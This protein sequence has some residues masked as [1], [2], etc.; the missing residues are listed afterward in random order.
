MSKLRTLLGFLFAAWI[1]AGVAP[2]WCG[3]AEKGN[4]DTRIT[5]LR[6]SLKGNRTCLIFD[7]EGARPKQ[8]GPASAEGIS[9]FFSQTTTKLPDKVFNESKIAAKEVKFRR[10]S[11]FFEVLFRRNNTTVSSKVQPGK[12]G[13]YTLTLELTPPAKGAETKASAKPA[14]E[15]TEK[16]AEKAPPIEIK[17]VET[18]EL[19]ASK[20][21][22]QV[23][24][25]LANT[26]SGSRGPAGDAKQGA[27]ASASGSKAAA[28]VEPDE[29]ALALYSSANEMFENCSRNLVSCA[30][31]VIEAYDAALKAGPTSSQAPLA[32]YRSALAHSTMGNYEKADKLFRQV[33]S[34]WP[35]H[36]VAIRCWI[37]IG[38]NHNRKQ[39]YLEA[40]EA[41]RW[42]LRGAE[43]SKDKAVAYYK[44]GK[45]YLLLGAPKEALEMLENCT[46]LDPDYYAKEPDVLR[47]SGE[48]QFDL[49]NLEKAKEH[50]LK[51]VNYQQ[52]ARDQ[53]VVFAKIAEIFLVQGDVSSAKKMY[54]FV[55]KYFTESEGDIICKIRK[56]EL[57]EKDDPDRSIKIYDALRGK[58][59]SPSLRRIVLLKLAALTIKKGDLTRSLELMDEAFPVKSDGSSPQGTSAFR[60][61]VLCDL[62]RRAFSD[63][64]FIKVVQLHDKYRRVFDSI[65]SPD[66]L[67]QIAESYAALKF[68]SNSLQIYDTLIA[69]GQKKGD[70]LLLRCAVYALRINDNGRAFQFCK[71]AQS[72]ALDLKKSEILG[73]IFYRDQ[74][75]ADALKYFGKVAPKGKELELEDPNSL[76]VFGYCLYQTKKFDEA[77]PVL[78]KA[79]LKPKPGDAYAR[80]SMLVTLG[81]CFAEQKQF[82]K[83]AETMEMAIAVS[84]E[85]QKNDLFYEISKLYIAAGQA[86]KA[87]QNL[88][89]IKGTGDPFWSAVAQQQ[90][91]TI[92]I[93]QVK[94]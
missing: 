68:Y 19:F 45:V 2:P 15:P 35:D 24:N 67:E 13:K 87:I 26:E 88:N 12:N 81:K 62:V 63:K 58:D 6:F 37:G 61:R 7:A 47:C 83:A 80:R 25:A 29:N 21:S 78:Q 34:R 52:S 65:Q 84:G 48:A 18:S 41:F 9:V 38:D 93:S 57:T 5:N 69:K 76:E 23:K 92:D 71:L 1:I 75:Y 4:Q 39:S 11:G 22:Q 28:F 31:D 56:A 91:N 27:A 89:Q 30:P 51:Y 72:D 90:I 42:A 32:I 53:D 74:K 70:D 33:I 14:P 3:A 86:D 40:V 8:I 94:Q 20:I 73:H 60:E 77:I 50:L 64:D 46:R 66:V 55:E 59:L 82:Q 17:K 43:E 10:E 16:A 54:A 44:L 85:D 49:G 79:M 36:P